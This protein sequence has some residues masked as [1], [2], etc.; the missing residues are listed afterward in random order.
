MR[1]GH[2]ARSECLTPAQVAAITRLMS[3]VVNSKG[4]VL[5]RYPYIPGTETEWGGWNY[6]ADVQSSTSSSTTSS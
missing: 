4:Q 6:D 3:P 5:Y 2:V 1:L